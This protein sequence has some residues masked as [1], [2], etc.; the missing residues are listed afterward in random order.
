MVMVISFSI[1]M[2]M[3]SMRIMRNVVMKSELKVCREIS[4]IVICAS[5]GRM[6][7]FN[8]NRQ[9]YDTYFHLIIYIYF[10]HQ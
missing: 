9:G 5:A 3:N 8:D 10:H 7:H 1:T 2:Q 6:C 4:F